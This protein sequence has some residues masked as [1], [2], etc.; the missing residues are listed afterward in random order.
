[1]HQNVSKEYAKPYFMLKFVKQKVS[2]HNFY[3]VFMAN[4]L[5]LQNK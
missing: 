1:M 3:A 5:C 2:W 4:M